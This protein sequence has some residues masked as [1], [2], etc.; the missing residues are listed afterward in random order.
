MPIIPSTGGHPGTLSTTASAAGAGTAYASDSY[1]PTLFVDTVRGRDYY[2]GLLPSSAFATMGAAFAQLDSW[3]GEVA[4]SGCNA[5]IYV[6]GNIMEQLET[7]SDVYGVR[8]VGLFNGGVRHTTA[9]GV[10]L[11]GNGAAWVSPT[12]AVADEPLLRLQSQGWVVENMLFVP[13]AGIAGIEIYSADPLEGGHA[14][15]R[16]CRFVA[17]NTTTT[18]GIEDVGGSGFVRVEDCFFQTLASGIVNTSTSQANPSWWVVTRN[19][20]L[21]NT[22]H[23]D[24]PFTKSYYT[25]NIHDEATVNIDFSGGGGGNAVNNNNFDNDAANIAPADGYTA[26]TGDSWQVNQAND[27]VYYGIPA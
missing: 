19:R 11:A 13:A 21:D 2:S 17:A 16:G 24:M 7:P 14:I 9:S 4:G 10:V 1:G 26:G 22:E 5:T 20:F 3:N 18:V 15:I 25:W 27:A 12:S 6:S 23:I 8:I